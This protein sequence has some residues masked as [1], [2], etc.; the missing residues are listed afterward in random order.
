MTAITIHRATFRD[1]ACPNPEDYEVFDAEADRIFASITE[2]AKAC[3]LT[4]EIKDGRSHGPSYTVDGDDYAAEQAAHDFM[5]SH[6]A[7]FWGHL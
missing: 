5:Q 2:K 1:A 4:V 6:H 3:G 7:D